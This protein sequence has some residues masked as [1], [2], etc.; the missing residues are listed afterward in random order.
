MKKPLPKNLDSRTNKPVKK[1]TKL[2]CK[3]TGSSLFPNQIGHYFPLGN[4]KV[5]LTKEEMGQIK[6][7]G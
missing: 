6:S 7:F 4:E 3:D 5:L 1:L 2:L